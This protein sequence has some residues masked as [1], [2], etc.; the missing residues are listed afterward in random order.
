MMLV[1]LMN[2]VAMIWGGFIF[3]LMLVLPFFIMFPFKW[4]GFWVFN[5]RCFGMSCLE[6][7]EAEC[8][9]EIIKYD[10]LSAKHP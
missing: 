3:N 4:M 8:E 7:L 5:H 9:A 1:M 6:I 2:F 10:V